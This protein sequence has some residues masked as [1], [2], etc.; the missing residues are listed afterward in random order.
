MRPR[1]EVL[2]NVGSFLPKFGCHGNFLESLKIWD[3]IF[4]FAD[5]KPCYTHKIC[6][7]ILYRN[8]VVNIGM[9]GVSSPLLVYA[10][11]SI[12]AQKIVEIVKN[13]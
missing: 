5:P 4:E 9:F 8:E 6:V 11:L 12:S 3:S 1:Q 2:Y 7:D 10:I 13:F